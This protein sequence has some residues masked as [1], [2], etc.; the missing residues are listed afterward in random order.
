[1][2][3]ISDAGFGSAKVVEP[4]QENVS[5][6]SVQLR[7]Y[8]QFLAAFYFLRTL[9][10]IPISISMLLFWRL[11]PPITAIIICLVLINVLVSSQTLIYPETRNYAISSIRKSNVF[12]PDRNTV[13]KKFDT[14]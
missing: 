4:E 1:M 12:F 5:M 2:L 6:N 14:V 13:C 10:A 9:L 7:L 11:Q 8:A 3:M